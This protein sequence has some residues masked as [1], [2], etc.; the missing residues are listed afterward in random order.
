[1]VYQKAAR[2][3]PSTVAMARFGDAGKDPAFNRTRA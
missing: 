2:K 1:M 3:A